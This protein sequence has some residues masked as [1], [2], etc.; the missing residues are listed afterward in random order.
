MYLQNDRYIDR[1]IDRKIDRQGIDK[2]VC[3][4]G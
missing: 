3:I 4:D 1:K 2:Y